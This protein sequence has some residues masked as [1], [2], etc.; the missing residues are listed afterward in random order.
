MERALIGAGGSAREIKAHM[1]TPNMP[2]F[3][4]DK[5]WGENDDNIFPLS[6]FDPN[7]YEVLVTVGDPKD[8]FDIIWKLPENTKYFT[9]IHPSAQ[10]LGD[11]IS[12]GKGTFIGANCILTCDIEIGKH[13]LINR[14]VQIGHDCIIGSY[15]S[16]MP[17]S[18][19]SGN[20]IIYDLV[21]IGTNSTIKEKISIHSLSTIGLNTGVINNITEPGTYIGTPARKIK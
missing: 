16:I 18:I 4:S 20:C 3:V 15:F 7:K 5:Y 12:I 21:Y 17:G 8:K 6:Q 2:C 13:A 11:N 19:I 14:G 10:L 9:Y 1:E